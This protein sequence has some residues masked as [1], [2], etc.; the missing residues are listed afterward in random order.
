[1]AG[2]KRTPIVSREQIRAA[3]ET[4]GKFGV[5]LP[6]WQVAALL[7]I[8]VKTLYEW[9]AHGLLD[10]AFRKRG[11][12][13]FFWRDKV[14]DLVLNGPEWPK[15]R[16]RRLKAISDHTDERLDIGPDCDSAR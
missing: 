11:K 4:D 14:V 12:H 10:G 3:F 5:I 9:I 13:H 16:G 15:A 8:S 2:S 6:T 7:G 1:M